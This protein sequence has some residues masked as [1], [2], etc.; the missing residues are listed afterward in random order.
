MLMPGLAWPGS[1][2][3]SNPWQPYRLPSHPQ[4]IL[5]QVHVEN[6][7]RDILTRTIFRLSLE[8]ID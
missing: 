5:Q 2:I 6:N 7:K 1:A 8:M 3:S 4:H